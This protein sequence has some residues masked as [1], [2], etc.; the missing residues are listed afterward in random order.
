MWYSGS[1]GWTV[2]SNRNTVPGVRLKAVRLGGRCAGLRMPNVRQIL[3]SVFT[4]D[5]FRRKALPPRVP[6]IALVVSE[7]D[8]RVLAKISDQ[9]PLDVHFVE[10][11]DEASTLSNQLTAPVILFDRDWPQTEWRAAVRSLAASPHRACVIL[12]SGVADD[13]LRQELI[14]RNGYD[15]LPKPLRVDNVSRVITLALS[16]WTSAA[17]TGTAKP[18]APARGS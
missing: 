1:L 7:H 15:V 14:R 11:C 10:S 16:Y 17:W 5:A 12:M 8:R 3:Y 13:Y 18:A 6:V 2:S 4:G 9:E